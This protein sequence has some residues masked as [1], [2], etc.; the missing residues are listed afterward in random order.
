MINKLKKH[1]RWMSA[2]LVA[3]L[4]FGCG[5]GK[6]KDWMSALLVASLL[7]GCGDG[8]QKESDGLITVDVS[9]S[10]PKKELILQ[11]LFDIE[12][13]PLETTDEMLTE[14]HIQY[15]GD[16]YM[17]FKNLGRMAGEIFIFDRQGKAVRKINR[18]GQ[19]GEEYLNIL[20]VDYDEETDELFVN[21]HYLDKVFVYDS[22]G[23]Y[24]RSFDY[25][26]GTLYDPIKI[27]DEER[28]IAYDD[29]FEY[30]KV[31]EKRDCYLILSRED[32]RLLEK[33][34][35]PYEEKKSLIILRRDLNGK[36]TGNW[37]I[38][39]TLMPPYQDGWLLIEPSADTI[40]TY[41]ASRGLMPLIVRTPPVNEMDPEVY[42]FPTI[43]TDRY[44]FMQAVERSF[45]F[46]VD[47]DVPRTNL[48]YD[49][50]E[51][52]AY[53]GEVINRDFEGTPVNLWF[54]HRVI[55]EFNDDEIAFATRLEAPDLVEALNDGKLR[56]P[57]KE[58]ASRLDEED[59]PV[60]LI[61]KYKK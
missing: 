49:K 55:M 60:I 39:N 51:Q 45:N 42:L 44:V 27:L 33:I 1:V 47:K 20:G 16:N 37:G 15:I 13:V 61:A 3:S 43:F 28:L 8:K 30:D 57:L 34:H 14:G 19:S 12:Y 54:A 6:Q 31:P 22:E 40:Y 53:E 17:I 5:D 59:N 26:D 46:G 52:T 21:S 29:Y 32:G 11:D 36:L 2:L 38:R 50:T 23:N 7:F 25:L 41:S 35:I 9:K 10:Y 18:L 24:K 58:I 48:I 56:G 4:L